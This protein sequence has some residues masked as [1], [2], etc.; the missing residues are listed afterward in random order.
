MNR[1]IQ[2]EEEE[3]FMCDFGLQADDYVIKA[4]D[5]NF[6]FVQTEKIELP[7]PAPKPYMLD[8]NVQANIQI[9]VP[10]DDGETQT[11][12]KQYADENSCTDAV[13]LVNRGL[14]FPEEK[15][16]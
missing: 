7:S 15:A 10:K 9:R 11:V 12:V 13:S 2:Y 5:L 16:K 4:K 6:Q 3:G 1:S 8:E 14:Q